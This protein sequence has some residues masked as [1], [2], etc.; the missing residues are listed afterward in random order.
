ML[1]PRALLLP[2]CYIKRGGVN[3]NISL[4][5]TPYKRFALPEEI[6]NMAVVLVSPIARLIV[7]DTIFMT[8]G[9]GNVNNG[10]ID[11]PF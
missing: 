2:H 1:W 5:N 6:A 8:G 10:D 11:Y 3:D 7:G 4:P 9:A